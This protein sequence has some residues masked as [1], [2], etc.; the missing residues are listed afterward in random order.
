[1]YYGGKGPLR[2]LTVVFLHGK[3]KEQLFWNF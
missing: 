1:M 3:L 2:E